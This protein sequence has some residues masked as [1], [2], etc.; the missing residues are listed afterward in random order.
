MSKHCANVYSRLHDSAQ[1]HPRS[2]D[3]LDTVSGML[4]PV[5]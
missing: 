3:I 4:S 5:M 1:F 2:G